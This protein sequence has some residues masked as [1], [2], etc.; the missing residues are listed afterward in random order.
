MGAL[1]ESLEN[2]VMRKKG[3]GHSDLLIEC[4]RGFLHGLSMELASIL[5]YSTPVCSTPRLS[6]WKCDYC[7]SVETASRCTKCGADEI[8]ACS[9]VGAFMGVPVYVRCG[10]PADWFVVL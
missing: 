5:N 2:A 6:R 1:S 10:K 4:S 7:Q 9:E 8:D 3:S